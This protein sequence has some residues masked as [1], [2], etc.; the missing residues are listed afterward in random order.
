M[1]L[2]LFYVNGASVRRFIPLQGIY[3]PL[4][5][6]CPPRVVHEQRQLFQI[7]LITLRR[8]LITRN[9]CNVAEYN[10]G[11]TEKAFRIAQQLILSSPE[12][13]TWGSHHINT[14]NIRNIK[15][16]DQKPKHS[17]KAVVYF[18]MSGG[19]DSFNLIV[20]TDDC[21]DKNMFAEYSKARRFHAIPK[22]ELLHI[23]AEGSGQRCDLWGINKHFPLLKDLY[24]EK[25]A[26]FVLNMGILRKFVSP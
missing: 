6:V 5:Q 9:L 23:D 3:G 24:D 26:M 19:V 20:P 13:H 11:D 7:C 1:P 4:P 22:D 8:T 25:D 2:V 12:F 18:K 14:G 16:N 15:G 10:R 17:Y 21:R